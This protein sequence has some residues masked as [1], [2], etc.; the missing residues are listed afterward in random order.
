MLETDSVS[1]DELL[2]ARLSL[3]VPLAGLAAQERDR[4]ARRHELLEAIAEAEGNHPASDAFRV[5]DAR[6]HRII[7]TAARNEILR[8]FTSWTLDVLQ[9]SLI[10]TIGDVDRRRRDPAPARR[11]PA[12][13]QAGPAR[14]RR[15]CDAAAS[16]IS[17][18]ARRASFEKDSDESRTHARVPPAARARSTGRVP[19]R[20]TPNDVLVRI[21]GAGV[22]ATDLHAH[23]GPDGAGRG[24]A[25]AR[26]RP[27]ERGLGR[28]GRQRRHDRGQGRRGARLSAR[29]AAASASPA[30]AATTCT[31]CS[32]SSPACRSTA[33]SPTTCVVSERSLLRLPDGVEPA[34]VAPHADAGLTAYH[35]VRR[36]AHLAVPG[37]TAV[38]IGVGGVGHIALQ[39]LRELGSSSRDRGRHRRAAAHGSPRELGADDVIDGAGVGR[40]GARA[41]R[42]PWRR[43]RLRLR[44][45]RPDRT[46]TRWR[47][48]PEAGRTR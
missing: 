31:A 24:L 48:S 12:G 9:P 42:R 2:A 25:A 17:S 26:A 16:R 3:E 10:D 46:P 6:F 1:L 8:A 4:D 30:A 34:A 35:A 13:D 37:T 15:A 45:H 36:L 39:L 22:C 7:A 41:H 32:T 27:R 29:T 44:R 38:V 19:S 40:C 11:D 43:S 21:G 28:G 33:A 5:A 23:G 18:G 47:C 14:R 20:C